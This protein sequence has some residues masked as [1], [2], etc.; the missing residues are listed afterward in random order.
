[1][2]ACRAPFVPRQPREP[3]GGDSVGR[4]RCR[5]DNVDIDVDVN[6]NMNATV[7]LDDHSLQGSFE[8]WFANFVLVASS[9]S[10]SKVA[11]T[12]RFRSMSVLSDHHPSG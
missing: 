8:R 2:A 5:S 7:D 9:R 4:Q 6:L 10:T 11:L 12:F 3:V 1:M